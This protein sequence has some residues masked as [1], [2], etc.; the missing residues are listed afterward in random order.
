MFDENL[1]QNPV[2]FSRLGVSP[3]AALSA[4]NWSNSELVAPGSAS[5]APG[6]IHSASFSASSS[7]KAAML[8]AGPRLTGC[9]SDPEKS[10][11]GASIR[12]LPEVTGPGPGRLI[13][14]WLLCFD[15]IRF[16][17]NLSYLRTIQNNLS[18]I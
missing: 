10:I 7:G 13:A 14:P 11:R 18:S 3:A 16:F 6:P 12:D 17:S 5:A 2:H 1:T 9:C 15:C 8:G 4:R